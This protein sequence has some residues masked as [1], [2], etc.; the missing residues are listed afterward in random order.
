VIELSTLAVQNRIR[1]EVLRQAQAATAADSDFARLEPAPRHADLAARVGTTREQVTRELSALTRQGLLQKTGRGL[2]VTDLPRLQ[3]LVR[4]ASEG[5]SADL[6]AARG[7]RTPSHD[8]R[9]SPR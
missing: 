4:G 2:L 7:P 9:Y 6:S 1:A 8:G 3:E 5:G